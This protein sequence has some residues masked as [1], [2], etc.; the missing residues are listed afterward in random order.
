MICLS[1]ILNWLTLAL[2]LGI[3]VIDFLRDIVN[4]FLGTRGKDKANIVLIL[5]LII[6]NNLGWLSFVC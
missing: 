6:G 3:N 4:Q 5:F 1:V 2:L